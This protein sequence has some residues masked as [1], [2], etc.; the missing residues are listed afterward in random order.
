MRARSI[1]DASNG[2]RISRDGPGCDKAIH[3]DAKGWIPGREVL[4]AMI[5]P[6]I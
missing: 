1:G 4:G 6:Q 2:I 5:E 3:L